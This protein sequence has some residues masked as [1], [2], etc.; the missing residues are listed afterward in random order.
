MEYRGVR[1]AIRLGIER[2]QWC[3]AI[4]KGRNETFEKRVSGTREYVELQARSMITQWLK[5]QRATH[6][7]QS[8][9]NG[10]AHD[11]EQK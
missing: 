10:P 2:G 3:V 8:N 6:P 1:Y 11:A 7:G 4:H 9:R 5:R